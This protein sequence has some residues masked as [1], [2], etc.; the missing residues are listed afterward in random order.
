MQVTACTSFSIATS[1]EGV[2]IAATEID[3]YCGSRAP[4]SQRLRLV[5]YAPNTH[6]DSGHS[7][8]AG[9]GQERTHAPQ[10]TASLFDQLVGGLEVD[11]NLVLRRGLHRSGFALRKPPTT[12]FR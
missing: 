12:G 2:P 8:S 10:Q 3:F 1:T 4:K 9:A 7:A 6:R 5:R 11:D